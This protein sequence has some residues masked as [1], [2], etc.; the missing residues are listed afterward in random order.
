[1]SK[2]YR[3]LYR[4]GKKVYYQFGSIKSYILFAKEDK[5]KQFMAIKREEQKSPK[6]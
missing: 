6:V 3:I 2:L 5:A 4:N 1:M